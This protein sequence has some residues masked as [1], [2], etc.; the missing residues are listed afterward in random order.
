MVVILPISKVCINK[1]QGLNKTGYLPVLPITVS[2]LE[3]SSKRHLLNG[4][5]QQWLVSLKGNIEPTRS[6]IVISHRSL[7]L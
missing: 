4:K 5:R 3:T 7:V 6:M 2:A 1:I